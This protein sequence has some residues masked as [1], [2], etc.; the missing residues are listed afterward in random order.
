[1]KTVLYQVWEKA[2]SFLKTAGTIILGSSI[3]LWFLASYP[4]IENGSRAE[5]LERSFA[6]RIGRQ[7]EPVLHPLGF[8]WKIGIGLVSSL[9]QREAFVSTMATIYNTRADD[10]RST[11]LQDALRRDV[12]PITGA[13]RFTLLTA[14]C[15]MVYYVL[16]MQCLSTFAVMR[17]ETRSWRW[18]F[19]QIAYMTLLAYGGTF[20]VYRVGLWI[21]LGA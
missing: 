7:M 20:V 14:L 8:D 2:L 15:L 12:D 13:R 21:G 5:Q 10:G 17:R 6:G 3:I 19:F 18:P 16:A 11:S 1:M 9:M 4:K